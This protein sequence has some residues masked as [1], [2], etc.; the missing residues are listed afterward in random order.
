MSLCFSLMTMHGLSPVMITDLHMCGIR[1]QEVFFIKISFSASVN[2]VEFLPS[3]DPKYIKL[4]SVS[5]D[6]LVR[7]WCFDLYSQETTWILENDG[8][9]TGNDGNLLFWVPSDLRSTLVNGPPT[10]ILDSR[11]STKLTLSENQGTLWTAC[12]RTP[13]NPTPIPL[14]PN[15]VPHYSSSTLAFCTRFIPSPFMRLIFS[16]E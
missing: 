15:F 7:I 1:W 9:L 4:A 10:R 3:T 16:S 11:F 2:C 13:P 5:V 14:H 6:G 8:W 12:H